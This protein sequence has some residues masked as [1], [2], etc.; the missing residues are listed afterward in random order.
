[1]SVQFETGDAWLLWSIP[2]C[3]CDLEYLIRVYTF[4]AR[5]AIPSYDS[6][7]RCLSRAIRAGIMPAPVGG[8]YQL[9]SEWFERVHRLDDAYQASEYGLIEFEDEF[10]AREW[11]AAGEMDF[12][13]SAGEYQQAADRVQRHHDR[14]FGGHSREKRWWE[15]WK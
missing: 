1:M 10:V 11:P 6:L 5:A 3:G 2:A 9:T 7:A 12:T 13:L 4:T 8:R 15:F 14:M